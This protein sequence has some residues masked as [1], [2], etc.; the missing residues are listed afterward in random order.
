MGID[1]RII[2]VPFSRPM[3]SISAREAVAT[4]LEKG[5]FAGQGAYS[6]VAAQKLSAMHDNKL[7]VLT[8][9]G[10]TALIVAL[11]SYQ[12]EP[13]DKVLVW[14]AAGFSDSGIG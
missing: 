12:L 6:S 7:V 4:A 1:G 9:S 11:L 5:A 8:N 14:A 10:T 2:E 3:V 13:G